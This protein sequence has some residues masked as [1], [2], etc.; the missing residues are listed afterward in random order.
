MQVN[1]FNQPHDPFFDEIYQKPEP[2]NVHPIQLEMERL[3]NSIF[4]HNEDGKR[5]YELLKDNVLLR[6]FTMPHR[7]NSKEEALYYEGFKQA[8]RWLHTMAIIHQD[9]VNGK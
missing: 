3:A 1:P 9:R 8:I 4:Y 7:D 5:L 6:S 2:I